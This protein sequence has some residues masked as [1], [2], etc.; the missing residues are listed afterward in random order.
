MS[1]LKKF[2]P[3]DVI[4]APL[5][6]EKAHEDQDSLNKYVF[7]VHKDANKNDVKAAIMYLYKVEPMKINLINVKYKKRKQRGLVR[8]AYKKAIITLEKKDKI[9]VG[10]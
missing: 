4:V 7:K 5:L 1:A 10:V 2:T 8:K 9:D 6:T 3:H